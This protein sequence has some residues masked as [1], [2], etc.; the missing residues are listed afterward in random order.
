MS[1]AYSKAAKFTETYKRVI[2]N[3]SFGAIYRALVISTDDPDNCGQVQ[4]YIPAIH[5]DYSSSYCY[6]WAIC[7]LACEVDSIVI[8][9]FED[10]QINAP[11]VLSVVTG[12]VDEAYSNGS[13]TSSSSTST[14]SFTSSQKSSGNKEM[15]YCDVDTGKVQWPAPGLNIDS[16]YGF[17]KAYGDTFHHGV[18]INS[19]GTKYDTCAGM[20]AVA[21]CNGTAYFNLKGESSAYGNHVWISSSDCPGMYIWYEH[22][23]DL[24]G[25]ADNSSARVTRGEIIG[26][27]DTT[28][29]STGPHLHFEIRIKDNTYGPSDGPGSS[30]DPELYLD[31]STKNVTLSKKSSST[32][33]TQTATSNTAKAPAERPTEIQYSGS[34]GSALIEKTSSMTTLTCNIGETSDRVKFVFVNKSYKLPKAADA[35]GLQNDAWNA[36]KKLQ[37]AALTENKKYE[38]TKGIGYTSYDEQKTVYAAAAKNY[39]NQGN[40]DYICA[41]QGYSEHMTGKAIDFSYNNKDK[42]FKWVKNNCYKYG[43]IIRY[44]SNN[45]SYTGFDN[46]CHLRFIGTDTNSLAFCKL[47]YNDGSWISIEKG[48]G[49]PSSY[50]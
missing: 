21:A 8:V 46:E 16:V 1:M 20:D 25:H 15:Y 22:L 14:G 7:G 34:L 37:S 47:L 2:D 39:F 6:P 28:G 35:S 23:D 3:A 30:V 41:K 31:T 38:I 43:F 26:H 42:A 24:N 45:K 9:G 40:V 12:G 18:D 13:L 32:G 5:G 48:Y 33:T 4:V 49:I 17:S 19:T 29:N 36:F 50:G 44:P 10:D 27:I 11:M